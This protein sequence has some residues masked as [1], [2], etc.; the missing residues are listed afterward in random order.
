MATAPI[1]MT[2]QKNYF[3]S[4]VGGWGGNVKRVDFSVAAIQM[5]HPIWR[6]RVYLWELQHKI[7]KFIQQRR[8]VNIDRNKKNPT[9]IL[10]KL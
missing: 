2:S 1:S 9:P 8:N 6:K 5:F 10:S 7:I 3:E 4:R